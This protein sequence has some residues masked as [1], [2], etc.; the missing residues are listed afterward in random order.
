M[1]QALVFALLVAVSNPL[2][3]WTTE[4]PFEPGPPLDFTHL[5]GTA[6]KNYIVETMGSGVALF[7]YDG[8]LD[9]DIYLVNGSTLERMGAGEPG[10]ANRLFRNDG[11]WSFTDVTENAGVGD[12]GFGQGVAV[13]DVDNDGDL[14]FY[15]TNYGPNV[16]Y[17]NNGDGT[18][19][20]SSAGAEEERWSSMAAFGD[21]DSDGFV[22]L[23]VAN[24]LDFDRELLDRAIPRRFCEWKGLKVQCGP[25]GFGF[26]SGVLYH[27]R[28]DGTFEDWTERAGVMNSETYQL[29]AIFSDLDL[30]GDQDLY[31]TTDTTLNLLFENQ[32]N[33]RFQD[34]SLLS[35]TALSQNGM[36][37]AGMGID[38]GDV[39]GDG[40]PD[41]FVTNFSDDYNTL[42][43]NQDGLTYVDATDLAGLG[44][45]SLRYLGWS[46]RLADLDADGDLDIFVVNGHVYPQVDGSDVGA[47]F[48][49][50]MQVFLNDGQGKFENATA[51]LGSVLS[52]PRA[53]RGAALG[54]LDG[55]RS[56]DVVINVMDGAPALIR[57]GL[58][59]AD[60]SIV[61]KLV[62]RE[63]NRGALGAL[64]TAQQGSQQTIREVR[65]DR[66]YQSHSDSRI[67]I[68]L[69]ESS[70]L[71]RLTIRWPSGRREVLTA[72]PSGSYVVL[73][74]A[75]IVSKT[76]DE[77][78]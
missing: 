8:D 15:V 67:Y 43:L 38:V 30:D 65:G 4:E 14:D 68:G 45:A 75:G 62:G 77:T 76:N 58:L 27:N 1:T 2:S 11:E 9:L 6:E 37:Q 74:G 69:G 39:N 47:S 48:R 13:A 16:L 73:E 41:L 28:G 44:L 35:G 24:Y 29:G 64:V 56:Q 26:V 63:S 52:E 71:D 34:L 42:Y 33:G 17:R 5:A 54:D 46:T 31:I 18:F 25:K 61:L 32:G 60:R 49:Q 57:N 12:R 66:G 7:D 53:S 20:V 23:Y 50:P 59:V 19:S 3:P 21:I 51:E 22:D 40:R 70:G 10:E 78:G 55:D 72:L 36:E